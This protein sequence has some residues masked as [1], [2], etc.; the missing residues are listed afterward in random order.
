MA[1]ILGLACSEAIILKFVALTVILLEVKNKYL[2]MSFTLAQPPPAPATPTKLDER[3]KVCECRLQNLVSIMKEIFN[4][5]V[6]FSRIF[7]H[8]LVLVCPY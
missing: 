8:Q 2:A 1:I 5:L 4:K 7:P 3:R 6:A